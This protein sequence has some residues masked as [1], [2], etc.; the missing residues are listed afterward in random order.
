MCTAEDVIVASFTMFGENK[1]W[2]S[3]FGIFYYVWGK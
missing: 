3:D 1:V 2:Y